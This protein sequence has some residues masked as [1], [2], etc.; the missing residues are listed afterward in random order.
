MNLNGT[1]TALVTPFNLQGSHEGVDYERLLSLIAFNID[2]GV[3]GIVLLGTTGEAA[4]VTETE[5]AE[6]LKRSVK[7]FG[8]KVPFIAG[9]TSNS[10]EKA[11]EL[12]RIAKEC[13]IQTILSAGPYYNKPTQ[14]GYIE[15]F[16]QVADQGLPVILYNVPSRTGGNILPETVAELSK[17]P[18]IVGI[19]EASGNLESPKGQ[20]LKSFLSLRRRETPH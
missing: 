6:I 19:K 4:T 9:A 3:D 20:I 16:T 12:V 18:N 14:R 1:I 2:N 17:H 11:K 10:T 5:Y 13:G 15:H 7:Q 8:A